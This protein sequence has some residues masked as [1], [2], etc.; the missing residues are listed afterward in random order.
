MG[1][2][3]RGKMRAAICGRAR[4]ALYIH[5]AVSLHSLLESFQTSHSERLEVSKRLI[6]NLLNLLNPLRDAV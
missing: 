6:Q 4:D 1:Q 3:K 2:K 5:T